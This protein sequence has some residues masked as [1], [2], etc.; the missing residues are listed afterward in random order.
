MIVL[1]VQTKVLCAWLGNLEKLIFEH[2]VL[3]FHVA[4]PFTTVLNHSFTLG[5]KTN[6]ALYN[7]SH[8]LDADTCG[9]SKTMVDLATPPNTSMC[10]EEI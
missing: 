6:S 4:G 5:H 9:T 3:I 8:K 10:V 2:P 7:P 1:E